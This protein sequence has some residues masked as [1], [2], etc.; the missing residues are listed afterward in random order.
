MD[1][2]DSDEELPSLEKLFPPK[3]DPSVRRSSGRKS[4]PPNKRALAQKL[5]TT[6]GALDLS[7]AWLAK[8]R[9]Q[10]DERQAARA[11]TEAMLNEDIEEFESDD[12]EDI[13]DKDTENVLGKESSDKLKAVLSRIGG[14]LNLEGGYRFIRHARA[15]RKF[16]KAWI[17]GV[18]WLEGFDGISFV[19]MKLILDEGTRTEYVRCGFVRDMLILGERL[20]TEMIIWSLEHSKP[21]NIP[22]ANFS[23]V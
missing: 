14:D 10:L 4:T 5:T 16:D 18:E 23:C 2:G 13:W 15:E 8:Q 9:E 17:N 11:R 1:L 7:M 20:P 19:A 12:D 3:L 6:Q 22:S 21:A